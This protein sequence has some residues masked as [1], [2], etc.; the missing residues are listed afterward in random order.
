MKSVRIAPVGFLNFLVM[1]P[2]RVLGEVVFNR[3]APPFKP[4][5]SVTIQWRGKEVTLK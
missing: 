4:G 1:T 2:E 5:V 3:Q